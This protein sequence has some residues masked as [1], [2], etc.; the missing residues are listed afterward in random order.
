MGLKVKIAKN[1]SKNSGYV[2][3][4]IED[5][6]S[7][8]HEAFS[9]P[10][11]SL[12]MASIGGNHSNQ[13][14]TGLD[15]TL[16]QNN[17]KVFIGYSD[18]TVLHFALATQSKLQTYYGPCFINQFGEY[19]NILGYTHDYFKKAVMQDP[20]VINIGSS[21]QYTDEVLDWF[22]NEDAKRA[23]RQTR[24]MGF[25]W[26]RAGSAGGHA[27][28]GAIPSINHLIGTKYL[29]DFRGSILM[30]DIPEGQSIYQGLAI[31]EADSW[32]TD[33]DNAG[34]LSV[35]NGL[36]IGRSYRYNKQMVADLKKVVL[37]ITARY[38]YP[39]LYNAD[40]GHTD[41]MITIPIASV[42]KL[43]SARSL[44]SLTNKVLT[45]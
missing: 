28:P 32:L 2:S 42:A 10:S 13:L 29:P 26:W 7:D 34:L 18:N 25:D 24:N 43:D 35:I 4:S 11:C 16:I 31:D 36:V 15:Y 9:D 21:R 12:V 39:I 44:F 30:I 3:A 33:L 5:R 23:R 1:A 6:I 41:P 14:I 37:R 38:D 8:I 19:P 27:L 45:K 22:K 17:P 40:F 20:Q